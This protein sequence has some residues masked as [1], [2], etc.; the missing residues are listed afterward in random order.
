M[1]NK[2]TR[3]ARKELKPWLSAAADNCEP[4]HY[5]AVGHSLL[6]S[7]HYKQLSFSARLVYLCLADWAAGRRTVEISHKRMRDTYGIP[8]STFI[9]AVAELRGAGFL[10]DR[11]DDD[12]EQF[13]ANT[14]TLSFDWKFRPVPAAKQRKPRGKTKSASKF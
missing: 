11:A 6:S 9:K 3:A 2:K 12:I 10:E 7:D 5:I 4:S 1:A 8:K 14:Y 13:K